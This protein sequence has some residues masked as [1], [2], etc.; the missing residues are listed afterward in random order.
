MYELFRITDFD[1]GYHCVCEQ[2]TL[3]FYVWFVLMY[4]MHPACDIQ[5]I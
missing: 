5:Y 1:N 3:L 4:K 2:N